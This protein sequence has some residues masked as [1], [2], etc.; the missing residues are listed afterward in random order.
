[1]LP[2]IFRI[3]GQDRV[4]CLAESECY[5][6][7]FASGDP[8]DDGTI[9]TI[10]LMLIRAILDRMARFYSSACSFYADSR[11]FWNY[12]IF[13]FLFSLCR[14]MQRSTTWNGF[15]QVIVLSM[16]IAQHSITWKFLI[17]FLLLSGIYLI[18]STHRDSYS[19]RQY[20]KYFSAFFFL[21]RFT[22]H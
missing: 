19:V 20:K 14:F 12:R 15:I 13:L 10:L 22:Q 6:N 1:M 2:D 11:Y 9:M 8:S 21:C 16:G 17:I 7:A 5:T 3:V 18:F 4:H